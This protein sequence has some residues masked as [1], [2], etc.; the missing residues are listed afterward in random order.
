MRHPLLVGER[1]PRR[2]QGQEGR[3]AARDEAHQLILP[4]EPAREVEDA[5]RRRLPGR[6][7]NRVSGLDNLDVQARD[8]MT[9]P[10]QVS[11]H[12]GANHG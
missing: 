4:A 9:V 8:G 5:P 1:Q 10:R 7:G 6:V 12:R 2:R 11:A 3:A